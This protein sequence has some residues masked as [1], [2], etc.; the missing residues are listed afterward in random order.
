LE[1]RARVGQSRRS[2]LALVWTLDCLIG[3]YLTLPVST[4]AF[5][6]RWKPAWLV[7]WKAGAYRLNFDLRRAGGSH[8]IMSLFAGLHAKGFTVIVITH[9][10]DVAAYAQR[11]LCFADGELI[12]DA[13]QDST[14]LTKR[15]Y[16]HDAW[17]L[18]L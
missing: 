18:S 5:W 17:V 8:E 13:A 12:A 15:E 16:K 14:M 2:G 4:G 7:K 6:R 1:T 9:E 3:F 10:A 11:V